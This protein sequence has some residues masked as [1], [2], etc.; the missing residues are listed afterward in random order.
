MILSFMSFT[1]CI[2]QYFS[3]ETNI[4]KLNGNAKC[5]ASYSYILD[6]EIQ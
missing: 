6:T 5:I 2:Y 4:F 1:Y 3:K